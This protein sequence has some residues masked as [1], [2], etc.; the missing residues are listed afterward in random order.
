M[1]SQQLLTGSLFL[2]CQCSISSMHPEQQDS[3]LSI[4]GKESKTKITMD[5]IMVV[6]FLQE[7]SVFE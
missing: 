7:K 1:F 4:S 3:F 6:F 5:K 2:N